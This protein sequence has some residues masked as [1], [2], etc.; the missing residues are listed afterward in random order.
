ME[1]KACPICPNHCLLSEGQLGACS[2]RT[3]KNGQFVHADHGLL[4]AIHIDPIEKKPLYHF[5]PST[6][7]LSIGSFGCNLKCRGCQNDSLSRV[8]IRQADGFKLSPERIVQEAIQHQCPSIAYTYNEPIVWTEFVQETAQKARESSIKNVV[9]TAGYVTGKARE[10]LFQNVDAANVD[11]KGFSDDFYKSWASGSLSPILETLE[12]LHHLPNFWLEITTLLIP[13]INT[14][15]ADLEAEFSWISEHL[16]PDVPLHLSAF[17]PAC[18]AKDIPRTPQAMLLMAL[19]LAKAAGL[20]FVYLGNVP[21][22]VPT[23]CPDCGCHII[24]RMAYNASIEG[25][26]HGKCRNCGRQ[27]P[28]I[29]TETSSI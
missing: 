15:P 1:K 21:L 2:A 5:L 29:W 7:A 16:G 22:A 23:T 13:E 8:N 4:S 11:L 10:T 28:G 19:N 25:L 18:E 26:I 12:Y 27:I 17:H 14:N 20:H 9:V 6:N 24:E 3:I